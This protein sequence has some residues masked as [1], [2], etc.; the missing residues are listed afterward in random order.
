MSPC[1]DPLFTN[2]S[3]HL[4]VG[5]AVGPVP[6]A[7]APCPRLVESVIGVPGVLRHPQVGE[8]ADTVLKCPPG[9]VLPVGVRL[10]SQHQGAA[11]VQGYVPDPF[12]SRFSHC[13]GNAMKEGCHEG[14]KAMQPSQPLQGG[15]HEGGKP[16][17]EGRGAVP[18]CT[19]VVQQALKCSKHF[20]AAST[21]PINP[22]STA[23]HSIR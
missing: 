21:E 3:S 14:R 22:I 23:C 9:Q 7:A 16:M 20:G 11:V 5:S 1:Y 15:C 13:R 4:E 8:V 18:H 12:C 10:R 6:S 2:L 19:V 17:R